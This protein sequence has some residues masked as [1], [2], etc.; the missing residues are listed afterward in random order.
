MYFTQ[1]RNPQGQNPCTRIINKAPTHLANL[2]STSKALEADMFVQRK[3]TEQTP[4]G[5][6]ARSDSCW[7][8]GKSQANKTKNKQNPCIF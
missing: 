1:E 3:D 2:V 6:Q 8:L 4:G 7:A 5:P